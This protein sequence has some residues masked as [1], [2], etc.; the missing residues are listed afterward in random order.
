M[1]LSFST[2]GWHG[3]SWDEFC[4]IAEKQGFNGIEL[5]NINNSSFNEKNGAFYSTSAQATV[6]NMYEKNLRIP[7]IDT[8]ANPACVEDREAF[9]K[10]LDKCLEIACTLHIPYV[11]IKATDTG[12]DYDTQ[13]NEVISVLSA[14]I[15]KAEKL[16]VTIIIET[17]GIFADTTKLLEVL[18]TFSCDSLA[19][20]WDVYSTYFIA[21]EEPEITIKNLGAYVKHVHVK[22]AVCENG[23]LTF[24]LIGEGEL[25]IDEVVLSLTSVNYNGYASI[26]WDPKWMPE[27]DDM[28]I[29]F[30]HYV[31]FMARFGNT[32]RGKKNLFWN[33]SHTGNYVWKKE[34]L[35]EKTFSQVLDRMVEE[36]PDQYAFKYTTLDYTRTYSQFRDD[37]DEC[38]RAFLALGVK[39][40]SHVA[41]W[42]T[43]VP[44]WYIAFWAATKI[45]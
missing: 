23:A 37:V 45:G 14:I 34:T 2:K 5:H 7:C 3:Y 1:K 35:I 20:L 13:K 21:K 31:S 24:C 33:K 18:N 16:G 11:R 19:A 17:A 4:N 40:G 32:S 9:T 44:Q 26:E 8:L 28:E 39:P 42:A 41:V 27:L 36:F 15:P 29:I 12:A 22:D 30:S 25:P 43:N 10:E 6:R 38:C